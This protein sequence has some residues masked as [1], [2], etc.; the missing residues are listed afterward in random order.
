MN[1]RLRKTQP[2]YHVELT[3]SGPVLSENPQA[4][5]PA[6]PRPVPAQTA[7][8]TP[9]PPPGPLTVGGK[10]LQSSG[11][12]EDIFPV[13][14]RHVPSGRGD[15]VVIHVGGCQGAESAKLYM[16]FFREMVILE[17]DSRNLQALRRRMHDLTQTHGFLARV[18]PFAASDKNGRAV[19]NLSNNNDG[20]PWTESNSLKKPKLHTGQSPEL[21]WKTEIEVGTVALDSI[22]E[23]MGKPVVHLCY[24]DVEGAEDLLLKGAQKMLAK[25]RFF[26]TEWSKNERYE[27]ALGLEAVFRMLPGKWEPQAVWDHGHFGDVLF[28][29]LGM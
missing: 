12:Y 23:N 25:T 17:P 3:Q 10:T 29:N 8:P 28:K 7:E 20:T 22:F 11:S 5:H 9:H 26:F 18:Y 24:C 4:E 6:P 21:N 13:L 16:A 27:G 15:G 1:Y 14:L 2:T 19:L